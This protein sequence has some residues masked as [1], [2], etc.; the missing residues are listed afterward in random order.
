MISRPT[1]LEPVKAIVCTRGSRDERGA[2]V[3]LAGQQRER[4]GRDAGLAQRL[5]RAAPR[6]RATAR[7]A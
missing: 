2:D 5:R 1:G 3:A 7:R 6:S 4:L